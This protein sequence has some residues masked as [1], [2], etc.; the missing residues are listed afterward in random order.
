MI[1]FKNDEKRFLFD[2][3][4]FFVDVGER[5]GKKARV[6]LKL[7]DVTDMEGNDYH[8]HIAQHLKK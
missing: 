8:T 7:Y 6:N 3:K 2:G 4:S 1:I 5:I